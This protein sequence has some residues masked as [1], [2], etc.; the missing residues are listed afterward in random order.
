MPFPETSAMAIP[1]RSVRHVEKIKIIP[2]DLLAGE[3]DPG[4]FESRNPGHLMGQQALLDF[5]GDFQLP[6][7]PLPLQ[8]FLPAA[9]DGR[10]HFVQG[11]G[12]IA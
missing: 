5:A 1:S 2:A 12:Q 6:F 9:L 8:E 10:G 7:E 11:G 4:D 3:A